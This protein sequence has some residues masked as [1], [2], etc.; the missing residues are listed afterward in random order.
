MP[1]RNNNKSN[2][3]HHPTTRSRSVSMIFHNYNLNP[4]VDF[5]RRS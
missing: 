5:R 4:V 1:S 2:K 3:S